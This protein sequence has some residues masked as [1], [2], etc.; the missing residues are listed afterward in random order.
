MQ[1]SV[2]NR[3]SITEKGNKINN[4]RL[5]KQAIRKSISKN[6]LKS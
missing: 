3:K 2:E 6:G 1:A 4:D 5:A